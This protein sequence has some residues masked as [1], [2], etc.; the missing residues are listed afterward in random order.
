MKVIKEDYLATHG[1]GDRCYPHTKE[2]LLTGNE[3]DGWTIV[4]CR[5]MLDEGGNPISLY[6]EKIDQVLEFLKQGKKVVICCGAGMSRSNAIAIGVLM[7]RG[8]DFE[9]ARY[10]VHD[11]VKIDLIDQAHINALKHLY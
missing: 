2:Q 4:D 11:K 9:E 8:Y 10:H 6:K 3:V 1:I 5:D 7:K